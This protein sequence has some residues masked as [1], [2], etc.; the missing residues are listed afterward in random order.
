MLWLASYKFGDDGLHFRNQ[1]NNATDNY[2]AL[3]VESKAGTSFGKLFKQ[4]AEKCDS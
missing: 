2:W 1:V 3:G 4:W